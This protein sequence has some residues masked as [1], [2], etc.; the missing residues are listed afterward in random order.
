MLSAKF[1][2]RRSAAV[3]LDQEMGM[4]DAA[5]KTAARGASRGGAPR[6]GPGGED[7]P[8]ARRRAG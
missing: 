5:G 8:H 7:R 4:A 6:Q 3:L 2:H 1:D